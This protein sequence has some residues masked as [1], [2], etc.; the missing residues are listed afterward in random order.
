M[1][2][3]VKAVGFEADLSVGVQGEERIR[4]G[5]EDD[6]LC[7]RGEVDRQHHYPVGGGKSDPADSARLQQVE[8]LSWA[9]PL[10]G[11]PVQG[12]HGRSPPPL[13][14]CMVRSAFS[15]RTRGRCGPTS[16]ADGTFGPT[17]R[18]DFAGSLETSR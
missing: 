10:Q 1:E 12:C 17:T 6:G 5:T 2:R 16:R 8:A 4:C 18:Q 14:V 3:L 11:V 7:P 9:E 13:A 15:S